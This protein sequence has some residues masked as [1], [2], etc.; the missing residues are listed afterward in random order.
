MLHDSPERSESE[1]ARAVVW[2]AGVALFALLAGSAE[3][4]AVALRGTGRAVRPSAEHGRP[5]VRLTL[6][7]GA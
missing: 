4:R 2:V 5:E 6:G 3:R 7:A 1:F